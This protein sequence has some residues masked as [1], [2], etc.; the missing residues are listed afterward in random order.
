V[1]VQKEQ[2]RR[3]IIDAATDV[4]YESGYDN[5]SIKDIAF[6]AG[7]TPGNIYS[8]FENKRSLFD[9]IIEDMASTIGEFNLKL[10]TRKI[11][12]MEEI[13]EGICRIYLQNEKPFLI[14]MSAVE[15]DALKG[16]LLSAIALWLS[17]DCLLLAA[18]SEG[19]DT[20]EESIAHTIL[21]GILFILRRRE[22]SEATLANVG[23]FLKFFLGKPVFLQYEEAKSLKVST[24]K[25]EVR[26]SRMTG[27]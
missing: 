14:C 25:G 13:A 1:Q 16:G 4:F 24:F 22:G 19:S 11:S 21:E 12:S 10:K 17:E 6:R 20:L 8:Y 15:A 27:N 18:G 5:A 26:D 23:G 9:Y 3:R 2:I 7:I